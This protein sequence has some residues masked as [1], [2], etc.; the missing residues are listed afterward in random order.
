MS[1]SKPVPLKLPIPERIHAIA[2]DLSDSKKAK[3]FS[4][5]SL[6]LDRAH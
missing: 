1:P 2:H 6:E 5:N 4:T 3:A